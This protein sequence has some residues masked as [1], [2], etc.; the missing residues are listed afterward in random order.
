M[1]SSGTRNCLRQKI[2]I[3]M[4]KKI[5]GITKC[6]CHRKRFKS[7]STVN[8]KSTLQSSKHKVKGSG[9][10]SKAVLIRAI[11]LKPE[12]TADMRR[13]SPTCLTYQTQAHAPLCCSGTVKQDLSI[14]LLARIC[15]HRLQHFQPLISLHSWS[16]LKR[17]AT[18]VLRKL[19]GN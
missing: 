5:S 18:Y 4:T 11:F 1:A 10:S 8:H 2:L 9:P 6:T 16:T 17:Y 19:L 14:N 12:E 3:V 13:I 15:I 7:S